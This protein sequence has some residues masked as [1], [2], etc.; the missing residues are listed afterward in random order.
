MQSKPNKGEVVSIERNEIVLENYE[1]YSKSL[2]SHTS[3]SVLLK[4]SNGT[5]GTNG[6]NGTNG[7]H[8][9][10]PPTSEQLE[11]I[12]KLRMLKYPEVHGNHGKFLEFKKG[13]GGSGVMG[14]EDSSHWLNIALENYKPE[15]DN[16][17]WKG[18]NRTELIG[19]RD[20]S[21]KFHVRYFEIQPGGHSSLEKHE[22]EHVVICFKG[23]GTCRVGSRVWKMS[24]GDVCYTR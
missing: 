23:E 14:K 13:F 4:D 7:H 10:P 12:R 16:P 11:Q 8:H 24:F 9:Q 21:P 6:T 2:P 17:S 3:S 18:V 15:I 19:R 5:K 1:T 20:E 22:H